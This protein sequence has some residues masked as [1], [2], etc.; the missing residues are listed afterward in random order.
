MSRSWTTPQS[1]R[2]CWYQVPCSPS[3]GGRLVQRSTAW[4][5][6]DVEVVGRESLPEAG[7]FDYG[8]PLSG[9]QYGFGDVAGAVHVVSTASLRWVGAAAD[10]RR[11]RANLVVELGDEAFAEHSLVGQLIECGGALLR[12]TE[13][14]ERCELLDASHPGME[15]EPDTL[16]RVRRRTGGGLGIYASVE[17]AGEVRSGDL[18]TG[19]R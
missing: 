4:L 1:A 8:L 13:V 19:V 15:A 7:F 14:T 6:R 16:E 9:S 11:V 12:V 2:R 3:R 10:V 18:F 5:G 17:R